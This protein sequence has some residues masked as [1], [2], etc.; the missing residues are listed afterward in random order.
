MVEISLIERVEQ[1]AECD[2][3]YEVHSSEV[4]EV[5]RALKV[6]R[7][8]EEDRAKLLRELTERED[9]ANDIHAL[10]HGGKDTVS[11]YFDLTVACQRIRVIESEVAKIDYWL[12]KGEA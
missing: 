2:Y 10:I 9:E 7:G 8:L 1:S 6:V 11:N 5:L 3:Y 4:P 12:G